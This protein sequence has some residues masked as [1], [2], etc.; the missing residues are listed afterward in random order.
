MF[1]ELINRQT[2]V[3]LFKEPGDVNYIA[4]CQVFI[5]GDVGLMYSINGSSFYD[6]WKD[7]FSKLLKEL[8][9]T[10]FQGYVTKAHARLMKIA[11]RSVATVEVLWEGEMKGEGMVWVCAKEKNAK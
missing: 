11:L 2:S 7:N 6:Y 1:H 5:Y 4:S 10:S 8:N 3:V 9:V